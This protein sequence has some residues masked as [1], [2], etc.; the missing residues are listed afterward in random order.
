MR[1][2]F[3]GTGYVGLVSGVCFAVNGHRV[4]CVDL[5]DGRIQTIKGG[6]APFHEPGL[7][8]ALVSVLSNGM[9]SATTDLKAALADTEVCFIAVGTPE[10]CRYLNAVSLKV[11]KCGLG[12]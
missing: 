2:T 7:N 10:L 5:D 11:P 3:V 1:I 12:I 4:T 6:V 9:F 8:E